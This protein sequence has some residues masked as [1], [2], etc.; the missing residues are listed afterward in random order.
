MVRARGVGYPWEVTS[1]RRRS[2]VLLAACVLVSAAINA[3]GFY[4]IGRL[5]EA[6]VP[7]AE[8]EITY[9]DLRSESD[10]PELP[11]ERLPLDEPRPPLEPEPLQRILDR[12]HRP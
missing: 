6:K 3:A 1:R 12:A 5:M 9:L 7:P 8:E 4:G 2:I 10:L 11:P